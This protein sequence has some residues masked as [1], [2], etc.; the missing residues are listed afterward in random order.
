MVVF[1]DLLTDEFYA[2]HELGQSLTLQLAGQPFCPTLLY[3]SLRYTPTELRELS[4]EVVL[5]RAAEVAAVADLLQAADHSPE[6]I[7]ALIFSRTAEVALCWQA[8]SQLLQSYQQYL[9]PLEPLQ[10]LW[11][12]VAPD[13]S[14][15][16]FLDLER[17]YHFQKVEIRG[18]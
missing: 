15:P 5:D 17:A 1:Q 7:R 13:S 11:D 14:S 10:K 18:R 12:F 4:L 8:D 9:L 3:V 2:R 6:A 16:L